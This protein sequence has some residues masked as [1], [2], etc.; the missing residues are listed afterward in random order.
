MRDIIAFL[1]AVGIVV[2]VILLIRYGTRRAKMRQE[3][4]AVYLEEA[5]PV[6]V[7]VATVIEKDMGHKVLRGRYTTL[8]SDITCQITFRL[9]KDGSEL[10]LDVPNKH[11]EGIWMNER[12]KLV[13]QNGN[14]VDFGDRTSKTVDEEVP[15]PEALKEGTELTPEDEKLVEAI[16]KSTASCGRICCLCKPEEAGCNQ[17]APCSRRHEQYGCHQYTCCQLDNEYDGCW[18]CPKAP[19]GEDQLDEESIKQRAF[20]RCIQEDGIEAF[21]RYIVVNNKNH[22]CYQREGMTG[23][24]DLENEEAVLRL[25]RTGYTT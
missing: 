22:I 20:V 11:Y 5:E 9:E 16:I 23:D 10:T 3:K 15:E 8:A 18:Q 2:W 14:F 21:T 7:R 12:A 1:G 4:D 19:C 17:S 24:Y 25:L 13:T 6:L